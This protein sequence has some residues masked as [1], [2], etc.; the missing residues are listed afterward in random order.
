MLD[1]LSFLWYNKSTVKE[2]SSK[3]K[4]KKH[5]ATAQESAEKERIMAIKSLFS[6]W[7]ETD[8]THVKR[9]IKHTWDGITAMNRAEKIAY[10]NS[11][12]QGATFKGYENGEP[13]IEI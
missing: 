7:K 5:K 1:K 13:I 6:G 3:R 10:I 4:K 11:R 2:K 8:L 12:L 9:W